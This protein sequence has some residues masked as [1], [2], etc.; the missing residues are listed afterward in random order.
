M[1]DVVHTLFEED[2]TPHSAEEM[3][4]KGRLR[5]QIYKVLYH[6]EYKWRIDTQNTA[7]TMSFDDEPS[8]IEPSTRTYSRGEP[9]KR[10]QAP[11][12]MEDI[13]GILGPPLG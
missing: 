6:E 10:V 3:E 4:I 12:P 7:N 8:T 2:Y 13:P 11:T 9:L 1:L 5:E